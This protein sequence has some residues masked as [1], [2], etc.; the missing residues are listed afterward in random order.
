M[1]RVASIAAVLALV[2]ASPAGAAGLPGV[3]LTPPDQ[4]AQTGHVEII[5][6][7]GA[8]CGT[9]IGAFDRAGR[10]IRTV[11]VG[12]RVLWD[13]T[14]AGG[15]HTGRVFVPTM[16][17]AFPVT[18]VENGNRLNLRACNSVGICR[19]QTWQRVR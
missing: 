9:V 4:K 6:C 10:P 14:G 13:V 5:P 17:S 18:L 16:N 12:R 19:S 7:G 11:A 3:W 15:R 2:V 1:T 8:M